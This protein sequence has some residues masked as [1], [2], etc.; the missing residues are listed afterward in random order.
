MNRL[1]ELRKR[2]GLTQVELAKQIGIGQSGYS[3]WERGITR[4]DSESLAK[5][6]AIFSVSV[7]YILGEDEN[8]RESFRRVP[9]LGSVPAGIPTDA[10]EDIIDWEDLPESMFAGGKEYFALEVKGNSMW[11]DYLPGDIVIVQR[12]PCCESGDVCVVYVNGYAATLK[13]VKVDEDGS[14]SLIPQNPEY[15]PRTY[16][17]EEVQSLPVTIC[18]VVVELR[19]KIQKR[20]GIR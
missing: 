7:G 15:P 9:V 11:P 12:Q 6:S 4:I 2:K 10:I 19:R 16:S 17:P 8:E 1:K 5:L 3:D 20:R 13:R 14:V 18:G